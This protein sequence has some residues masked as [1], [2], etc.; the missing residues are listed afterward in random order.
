MAGDSFTASAEGSAQR[1]G[2]IFSDCECTIF[3]LKDGTKF[4]KEY[5][6]F[7]TAMKHSGY[8]VVFHSGD[9]A[10][11]E[12][13]LALRLKTTGIDPDIFRDEEGFL[14]QSKDETSGQTALAAF[15]DDHTTHGI[16]AAFRLDTNDPA[17]KA[18]IERVAR[19]FLE[20]DKKAV[21]QFNGKAFAQAVPEPARLDI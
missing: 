1:R 16:V 15:D 9:V 21:F 10:T 18:E 3:G 17:T 2:K 12:T 20:S 13:L 4:Y 19:I 14:V 11:N 8:D 7:L 5:A 6:W